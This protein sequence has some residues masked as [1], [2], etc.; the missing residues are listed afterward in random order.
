VLDDINP[1]AWSRIVFLSFAICD[2]R[3]AICDLRFAICRERIIMSSGTAAQNMSLRG[4]LRRV[5]HVVEVMERGLTDMD[6][7]ACSY[8]SLES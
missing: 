5:E 6:G 4:V 7:V 8:S 1:C 2:L 3:F